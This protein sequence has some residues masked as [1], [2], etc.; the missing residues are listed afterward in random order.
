[1]TVPR[2]FVNSGMD[3]IYHI[4]D[5]PSWAKSE[6]DKNYYHPSLEKEGFI[7]C[8]TRAQLSATANLYFYGFEEITIVVLDPSLIS[9]P[10]KYEPSRGGELFPHIYGPLNV[11]SVVEIT[12]VRRGTNGD[13]V[14]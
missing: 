10:L 8:S 13:F 11:N 12:K 7:H 3:F 2:L 6:S 9:S 14:I 5:P 1:M 4:V